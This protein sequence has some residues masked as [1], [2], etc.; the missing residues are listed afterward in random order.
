M[1]KTGL[2]ISLICI[3]VALTA[4]AG[5]MVEVTETPADGSFA[6]C[7][8]GRAATIFT[9]GDDYKVVGIAAGMLADDVERVTGTCQGGESEVSPLLCLNSDAASLQFF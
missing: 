3:A 8:N 5:G 7:A 1:F 6:L 2:L 9:D 4:K